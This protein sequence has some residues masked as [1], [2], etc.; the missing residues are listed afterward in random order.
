MFN[1]VNKAV[2]CNVY[3]HVSPVSG[4]ILLNFLLFKCIIIAVN[5]LFVI[6]NEV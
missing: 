4:Y 1:V 2:K 6:A 3:F 5:G